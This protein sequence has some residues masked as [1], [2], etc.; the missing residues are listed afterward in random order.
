MAARGEQKS[1]EEVLPKRS[2]ADIADRWAAAFSCAS[3]SPGRAGDDIAA[4]WGA[5]G[6]GWTGANRHGLADWFDVWGVQLS[7]PWVL[8]TGAAAVVRV[9]VTRDWT[10]RPQRHAPE[11][12]T[13]SVGV[14]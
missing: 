14:V 7:S 2:A 8:V 12:V 9:G 1:G 11:G 13:W 4:G 5:V 10:P 3:Q 6:G